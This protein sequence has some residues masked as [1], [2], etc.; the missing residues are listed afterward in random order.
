MSIAVMPKNLSLDVG[1]NGNLESN[2]LTFSGKAKY[3]I[4]SMINTSP[5]TLKNRAMELRKIDTNVRYAVSI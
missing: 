3:G 2:A 5:K 4:P 1:I